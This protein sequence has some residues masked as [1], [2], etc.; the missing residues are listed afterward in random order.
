MHTDEYEISVGREIV[1]CRNVVDKLIKSLREKEKRY[2][3][4]TEEFLSAFREGR[5]QESN[6]D[7]VSWAEDSR[8]LENWTQ[9]LREY[10]E[11]FRTLKDI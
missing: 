4:S 9:K 11:A 8:E 3:M 1:L 2:G 7:F 6:R 5:F 10:E